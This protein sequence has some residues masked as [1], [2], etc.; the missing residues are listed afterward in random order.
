LDGEKTVCIFVLLINRIVHTKI[1]L[2]M[3]FYKK[4]TTPNQ[5]FKI[6]SG[7][8]VLAVEFDPAANLTEAAVRGWFNCH[9]WDWTDEQIL[10]ALVEEGYLPENTVEIRS[11]FIDIKGYISR[12]A[13]EEHFSAILDGEK[14][15][16]KY[17]VFVRGAKPHSD[18]AVYEGGEVVSVSHTPTMREIQLEFL[19]KRLAA[20]TGDPIG[21]TVQCLGYVVGEKFYPKSYGN[22]NFCNV[23]PYKNWNGQEYVIL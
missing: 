6:Q 18:T 19:D 5:F 3:Q 13:A 16:K 11:T 12:E 1:V 17:R 10:V 15:R 14:L 23:I 7:K 8:E 4:D 21:Y 2:A 20:E 22:T 9:L